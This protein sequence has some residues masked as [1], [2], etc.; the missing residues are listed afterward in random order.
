PASAAP[1]WTTSRRCEHRSVRRAIQESTTAKDRPAIN[2]LSVPEEHNYPAA[3]SY[4]SL[5]CDCALA[6]TYVEK[7][8]QAPVSQFK[9]KDIFRASGLSLL[10]ISNSHVK[11]DQ[12]KIECGKELS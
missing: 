7:L 1:S 10:G 11:K 8:K 5:I 6:G 9:A 2:W 4:L 12:R 3:L